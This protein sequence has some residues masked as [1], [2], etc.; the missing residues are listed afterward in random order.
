VFYYTTFSLKCEGVKSKI[1]SGKSLKESVKNKILPI[2]K[3]LCTLS[4]SLFFVM[5]LTFF[6]MKKL[7]G[8]PFEEEAGL[9]KEIKQALFAYYGLDKNIF[10]QYGSYLKGCLTLDFGP[11]FVHENKHVTDIIKEGLPVSALIGSQAFILSIFLGV[12]LGSLSAYFHQKK[13]DLMILLISFAGISL[14]GFLLATLLQHIFAIHWHLLPLARF[15]GYLSSLLPSLSLSFLPT[16]YITRLIRDRLLN[17]LHQDY[18]KLAYAKGLYPLAVFFRHALRNALLPLFA[19]L[20]PL[21]A[22]I[23][24]GSFVIEKI[25]AL[26]GLGQWMVKSIASRDYTTILGLTVFY[27]SLLLLSVFLFDLLSLFLDPRLGAKED[28]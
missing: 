28:S 11:S 21:L 10:S 6:L 25:F 24:T 1:E 9:R 5:T 17:I 4:L 7:P 15:D 8:D 16:A 27:S 12:S 23:L 13:L 18:I 19:Y 26:P 3:K 2:I 22:H 20:G 14:P